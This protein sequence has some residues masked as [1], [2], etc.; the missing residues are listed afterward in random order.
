MFTHLIEPFTRTDW[1][2]VATRPS[3]SRLCCLTQA[4]S[5]VFTQRQA[6]S[7]Y[8]ADQ[9]LVTHAT[10]AVGVVHQ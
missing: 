3:G 10:Q 5:L 6:A 8:Q 4:I 1:E 9:V 2:S 7:V